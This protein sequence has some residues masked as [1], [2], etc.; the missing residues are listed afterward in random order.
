MIRKWAVDLVPR[1]FEKSR[2]FFRV[3]LHASLPARP[4]FV[5][6]RLQE[7]MATYRDPVRVFAPLEII[8]RLLEMRAEAGRPAALFIFGESD[9]AACLDAYGFDA[10]ALAD[11]KF[12]FRYG[13]YSACVAPSGDHVR[14]LSV[15]H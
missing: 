8:E 7:N 9:F 12:E 2:G 11:F 6:R 1:D 13:T 15:S 14:N 3:G 5:E 10:F 4:Q